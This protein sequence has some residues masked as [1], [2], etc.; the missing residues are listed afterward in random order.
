LADIILSYAHEDRPV[1]TALAHELTKLDVDVWWDHDLTGGENFRQSIEK[2]LESTPATIVIWSRRSVRSKWVINEATIAD[3]NN[4]MIPVSIDGDPP[5][6]DFRSAHTI[7]LKDWLPGDRLPEPLLRSVAARLRRELGYETPQPRATGVTRLRKR[8]GATW[9]NDFQS[10][11]L[12]MIGQGLACFLV[13]ATIPAI[14]EELASSTDPF[15]P[16]ALALI[17]SAIIAALYLRPLLEVRRIGAATRV[18]LTALA[19]GVLAY[20]VVDKVMVLGSKGELAQLMIIFGAVAF[21]FIL[22]TAMAE[23]AANRA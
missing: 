19:I 12:Y 3:Q 10:A 8:V 22:I 17:E 23:S 6:I 5:P 1:A 15:F 13:E 4:R 14:T 21:A 20:R 2:M 18:F 7:D 16:Y 11:V 9:Y